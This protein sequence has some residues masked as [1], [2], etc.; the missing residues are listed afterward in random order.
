MTALHKN[1][2]Q[3]TVSGTPGTGTITLGSAS[4]GYQSF[5]AAYAAN[6]TVDV[7][8]TDGTA[9][10]VARDCTYTNS[11][12]TLSRGT[13]EDS[14]TGAVLNLSG[15]AVVS[16]I[17][18]AAKGNLL[19]YQ[20]DRAATTITTNGS[21]QQSISGGAGT[22]VI[23]NLDTVVANPYGWWDG[24]TNKFTPLRAGTYLVYAAAQVV[25]NVQLSVAIYKNGSSD[26]SGANFA[27]VA[28][29]LSTAVGLITA[30]GSTD[31]F[32][33]RAYA[34]ANC[35]IYES[36]GYFRAVYLGG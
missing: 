22:Y 13:R 17:L 18:T 35:T 24:S 33:V 1:K 6:A 26:V 12:T 2:V 7:L 34:G 36:N 14:S 20:L 31:Y 16:V 27:T 8:I 3:M 30:N 23:T 28:Y 10:E 5:A 25:Q 29:A 11:G 9:W 32:D 21:T 19:E 4:T 15:S